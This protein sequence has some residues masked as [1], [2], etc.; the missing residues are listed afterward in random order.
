MSYELSMQESWCDMHDDLMDIG[1]EK[2]KLEASSI[3]DSLG[4]G[5]KSSLT[6]S[7]VKSKQS[8][9]D[10][11]DCQQLSLGEILSLDFSKGNL[12]ELEILKHQTYVAGQLKK[13]ISLCIE[14]ANNFDIELHVPKLEWL[15]RSSLFLAKKR[16][17][18]DIRFKKKQEH[19][20]R[21]SYEFCEFGN[22]CDKCDNQENKC[23]KK[24]YVYNYVYCDICE[25]IRYLTQENNK[26]IKEIF[27]SIN[28]I[29]YVF[30]HMYDEM[31]STQI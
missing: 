30:N 12:S 5:I 16:L 2:K 8:T 18:K 22:K 6:T 14:N 15:A 21:N 13:Y 19:I 3:V 28:T 4:I 9:S 29:N 7:L 1:E 31:H 11:G 25:L 17:Q 26:N 24:H 20:Q 27:T 23:H 10:F